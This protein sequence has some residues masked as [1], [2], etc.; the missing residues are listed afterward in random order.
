MTCL[1]YAAFNNNKLYYMSYNK[2]DICLW[3]HQQTLEGVR[4]WFFKVVAC[5]VMEQTVVLVLLYV[6][7]YQDIEFLNFWISWLQFT[8]F[9]AKA[10]STLSRDQKSYLSNAPARKSFK[11]HLLV[12]LFT[13]RT[14]SVGIDFSKTLPIKIE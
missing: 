7:M 3:R 9:Y 13:Y 12:S 14:L 1:W 6:N 4:K 10:F 11:M 2:D 5:C 8:C